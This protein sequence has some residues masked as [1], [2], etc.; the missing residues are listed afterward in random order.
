MSRNNSV[1]AQDDEEPV[2]FRLLDDGRN[3][4][5]SM[6]AAIKLGKWPNQHVAGHVGDDRLRCMLGTLHNITLGL[7]GKLI[8]RQSELGIHSRQAAN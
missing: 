1:E 6:L 5:I 4:M 3:E 2:G 8:Y 7:E